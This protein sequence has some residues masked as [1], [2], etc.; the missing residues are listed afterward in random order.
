MQGAGDFNVRARGVSCH[1]AR[2]VATRA[3]RWNSWHSANY[4]HMEFWR[5]PWTCYWRQTGYEWGRMT[6]KASY[7]RRIRYGAGA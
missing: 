1:T 7:G 3:F 2:Y 5:G 6:C 4:R